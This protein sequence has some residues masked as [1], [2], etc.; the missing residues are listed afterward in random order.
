MTRT[1]RRSVLGIFA[2]LSLSLSAAHAQSSV[3]RGQVVLQGDRQPLPYT[4]VMSQG[5]QRLTTDS[6]TF[7]LIDLP[8]G[9]VRL[10]FKRIGFAPKDTLVVLAPG[11]ALRIQVEMT[12]LAISLPTVVVSGRCTNETPFEPKSTI[13][14]ELF[15]QVNQH[16]ERMT[17]LATAKPFVIQVATVG[18]FR[19]PKKPFVPMRVDTLERGPLP[20]VRYEPKRVARRGTGAYAG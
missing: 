18:G 16:A 2:F 9:E 6:G 12:P 1:V 7:A 13:L 17:L 8:P 15:D 10:R 3:V 20:V 14:A 19:D 5:T 11:E 4:T